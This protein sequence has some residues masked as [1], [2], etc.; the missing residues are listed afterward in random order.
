[1]DESKKIL[2]SWSWK[3]DNDEVSDLFVDIY[4]NG[5]DW[6]SYD[7][8]S[9]YK[10]YTTLEFQ[11]FKDFLENGSPIKSLNKDSKI[12]EI[13]KFIRKNILM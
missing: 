6:Y 8:H 9:L 13:M 3:T 12:G 1:M 11:L 2:A 5:L 10:G 4:Q 7:K